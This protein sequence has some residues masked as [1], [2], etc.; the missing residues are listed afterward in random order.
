MHGMINRALQCFLQDTYGED[1]WHAIAAAAGLG[2]DGFEAMLTYPHG[3][4][5][6]V[7]R[8]AA[9]DLSRPREVILDD[10]GTYLVSHPHMAVIRRLLRFGGPSFPDF[11]Y[12]LDHLHERTRLALPDLRLPLLDLRQHDGTAFTLSV[13]HRVAGFGHVAVGILRAMADDYGAL[14]LLDHRGRR[15]EVETVSIDLAAAAF[16]EPRTFRL[17][18][19]AR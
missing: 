9:S 17:G 5:D 2:P 14:V 15:G 19:D 11:L 12:S 3:P 6:A 8:A 10:I 1:R 13:T 4:A 18:G 7:L 16:A